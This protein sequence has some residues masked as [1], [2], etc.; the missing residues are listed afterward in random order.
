MRKDLLGVILCLGIAAVAL[1]QEPTP[2]A[3]ATTPSAPATTPQV[4]EAWTQEPES[5]KDT[6]FGT[7]FE[8]FRQKNNLKWHHTGHAHAAMGLA[9]TRTALRCYD[10]QLRGCGRARRRRKGEESVLKPVKPDC[11][12]HISFHRPRRIEANRYESRCC[13]RTPS[14]MKNAALAYNL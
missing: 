7:T 1:S 11:S 4:L 6:P 9:R 2:S 3:S 5:Y 14:M 8:A 13:Y 10:A 12:S